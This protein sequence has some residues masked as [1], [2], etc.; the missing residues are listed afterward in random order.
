MT[1][2]EK[3]CLA[4]LTGLAQL[5]GFNLTDEV[6]ALYYQ[7]L[8]T[9][10]FA[11]ATKAID[12]IIVTRRSRDPF[13]SIKEIREV[14]KPELRPEDEA[15]EVVGR[16]VQ[17]ISRCGPYESPKEFLGQTAWEIVCEEGGWTTVCELLTFD[18][19]PTL[20]AQWRRAAEAKVRRQ[21]ITLVPA[22]RQLERGT[23][24]QGLIS[25]ADFMNRLG[26]EKTND[27]A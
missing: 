24:E 16:I 14:I 10:G 20:K 23:N 21:T 1:A 15:S 11:D 8:S 19:M 27:P 22:E 6:V 7:H 18:N 5:C 13:P 3:S 4:K 25:L 26:K 9:L 2:D 17:A 12:H